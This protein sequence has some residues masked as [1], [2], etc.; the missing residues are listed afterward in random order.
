MKMPKSEKEWKKK[1]SSEQF[2]VLRMKGTEMPFTGKYLHK[3]E[4]GIYVC[5]GCGAELF[6]SE[7][8]FDSGTGWPSFWDASKNVQA[9]QDS[10][11]DMQRTEVL[12]KKCGGHLGHLFDDRPK[13]A[14]RADGTPVPAAGKRF[15]V[16]SAALE[17]RKKSKGL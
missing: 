2:D 14:R 15:C 16:N 13:T 6:D 8:K 11:H 1:L 7:K 5:A 17:F 3:M 12:C 4:K 10:S 9:K